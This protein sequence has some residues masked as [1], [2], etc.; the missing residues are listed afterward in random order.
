MCAAK[1][2]VDF[3]QDTLSQV[4][5]IITLFVLLITWSK[6]SIFRHLECSDKNSV[7]VHYNYLLFGITASDIQS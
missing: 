4:N 5:H 1:W 2:Q 3:L 6:A 7:S